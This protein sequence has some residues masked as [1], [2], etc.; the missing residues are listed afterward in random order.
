M[1]STR[2]ST[3]ELNNNI[4]VVYDSLTEPYV[5]II[6]EHYS[7]YHNTI[8][9]LTPCYPCWGAQEELFITNISKYD[10]RIF[11]NFDHLIWDAYCDSL[12]SWIRREHINEV[13][14]W[15]L[16]YIDRY[17][18]DIKGIVRFRPVRYCSY[19]NKLIDST[20]RTN[21]YKFAFVGNLNQYRI[22]FMQCG[23]YSEYKAL[24]GYRLDQLYDEFKDCEG[25][26]NIHGYRGNEQEQLRIFPLICMNIPVCSERSS[27]NYFPNIVTEI[28]NIDQIHYLDYSVD[29]IYRS[30]TY[31]DSSYEEYCDKLIRDNS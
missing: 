14:E 25:V 28:D 17:P 16:R 7:D 5:H 29:E 4:C 3:I 12:F 9:L 30:L 21:R 6:L 26:L 2:T 27:I 15:Q 11:C 18:E 10:K 1:F 31:S 24:S 23:R 13:W 8:F 19:Y 20:P 22:D